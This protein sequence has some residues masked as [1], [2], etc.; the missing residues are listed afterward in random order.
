MIKKGEKNGNKVRKKRSYR[1]IEK[2]IK[3]RLYGNRRKRL[4]EGKYKD[5]MIRKGS[6]NEGN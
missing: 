4:H 1:Q 2:C 3:E 6:G 5:E